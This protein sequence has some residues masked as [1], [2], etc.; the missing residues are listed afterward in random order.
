MRT[1]SYD[2]DTSATISYAQKLA[3]TL[4]RASFTGII[5]AFGDLWRTIPSLAQNEWQTG[6]KWAVRILE[7]PAASGIS[8]D[9]PL[10]FSYSRQR[11]GASQMQWAP[12]E[13]VLCSQPDA[14]YEGGKEVL[15]FR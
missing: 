2:Q 3:K 1:S 5:E 15:R 12:P 10:E 6:G 11:F 14:S 4:R 13:L 9:L 7:A 8:L